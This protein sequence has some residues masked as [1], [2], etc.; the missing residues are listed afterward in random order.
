M[1]VV[2]MSRA[3]THSWGEFIWEEFPLRAR[4]WSPQA[5][6]TA[7]NGYSAFRSDTKMPLFTYLLPTINIVT[8]LFTSQIITKHMNYLMYVSYISISVGF[9]GIM[10]YYLFRFFYLCVLYV[11]MSKRGEKCA[12]LL[13]NHNLR[14]TIRA[15][16]DDNI[17]HQIKKCMW[18][19]VYK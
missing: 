19:H 11:F 16:P 7:P 13:I 15:E 10:D 12:A 2:A 17:L 3:R 1:A 8:S 18:W 14:S 4:W 9:F 6:F 5:A